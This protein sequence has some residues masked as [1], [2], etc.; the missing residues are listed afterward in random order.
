LLPEHPLLLLSKPSPTHYEQ[1]VSSYLDPLL[2]S[3]Q[4]PEQQVE[5]NKRE[6]KNGSETIYSICQRQPEEEEGCDEEDKIPVDNR[7]FEAQNE[8]WQQDL[9]RLQGNRTSHRRPLAFNHQ[10]DPPLVETCNQ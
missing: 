3:K 4:Q 8:R 6:V 5:G 10:F 9:R 2:Q 7:P 1:T